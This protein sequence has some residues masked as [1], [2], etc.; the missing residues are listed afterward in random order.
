[1]IFHSAIHVLATVSLTH[2]VSLPSNFL[3]FEKSTL[4]HKGKYITQ[5]IY[6]GP[7]MAAKT[8]AQRLPIPD[9]TGDPLAFSES[10]K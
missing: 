5:V 9:N 3:S 7:S 10:I 1:M 4:C 6:I 8:W 2:A